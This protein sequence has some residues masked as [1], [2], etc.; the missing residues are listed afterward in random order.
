MKSKFVPLIVIMLISALT[1]Y[2]QNGKI[3]G[4]VL[5]GSNGSVLPDAVLKIEK[6]NKGTASD[7][8]GK[9]EF[10]GIVSGELDIKASYVGYVSQNVKV[11]LKSDDVLNV[12]FVLQPEGTS[13]DT[14]TIEAERIQSN[15][16]ALLLKQQ[17]A[18][19]IQDGI[20]SQQI[21][22]TGDATSSE[23]LKR[24]VGV[25]IVDNKFVFVRGTNERYSAT[26]LNGVVLPSTDPDKKAFSFDLF[27]S[28]L[29]DN[30]VISKSYTPDL[31]GNFSGGLVQVT[32]KDFPEQ[33]SLNLSMTS[34]Y[35]SITTGDNFLSY[36]AGESKILFFNSGR[37]NG[38]RKLP[39]IFPG[40]TVLSSNYNVQEVKSFSQ[41]FANNWQQEGSKAPLNGGFQFSLGNNFRIG[42]SNNLGFFGAYTYSN[43]FSSKSIERQNFQSDALLE[44]KYSGTQSEY[45]VMWGGL[46]NLSFRAGD[47]NKF[48]FKNTYVFN[49]EDETDY[50]EGF[51]NT[52]TQERKLYSTK[53]VQRDMLSSQFS[54][55]HFI[56]ELG[57]L[58]ITWRGAYSEAKRDEP[59][60]KT[61]RYQREINTN[62][63]FYASL[64]TGEPNSLGGGRFFSKLNDINRSLEANFEFSFKPVKKIEIKSK[65][66]VFYNKG[67]RDFN[68]RLFAPKLV[69]ANNFQIFYESPDSLFR[70]ENIDT[71]KILYYELTRQSDAYTASDDIAAGY[72][73]F[74][75]PIGK[76]RT[77]IGARL[78]SNLSKLS[79]FDQIGDPIQRNVNKNDLLPSLN[80]TYALSPSI[81]I[82][83]GYYQSISRPEF[84]EIAPFSFYDFAEQIFTIGNP[85]IERNLIRN[86]DLR[87]EYYPQAG[88]ILSLSLFYK[89]FDSPIEEVFVPNSGGDNRIKTFQNAKGGA[90]N[91]G[92]E[93]EARKNLGF[94]G[95]P[96]KYFSL[97]TNISIINSKVNLSG[98]GTTATNLERRL[99][100]Q[101]PYTINM[102]LYYDNSDL[103][104]S[105]NLSYNRFGKRISEVGLEGL[106]DIEENG[107]DVVDFSVIQRLYKN[108]EVKLMVKDILAQDYLYTQLVEGKEEMFKK[109]NAGMGLSLSLTFKY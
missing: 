94:I 42:K 1:V 21:K 16:A 30:I 33:L 4:K 52:Q 44:S 20:S 46:L 100:G 24:I 36:N 54:G 14:V 69:D 105:V 10:A 2:S 106:S 108:F 87:F 84:R 55:E 50:S 74:D 17:K 76:L 102:G 68:A 83:G 5:D 57:K 59:D 104:T 93:L 26:T 70:Q 43:S 92:I 79:S 25:S 27:P 72:L 66:G 8:D 41:A 45:A 99:Q 101:S 88:E 65:F 9:Y 18:D 63:R 23:V 75:I 67:T 29:L 40:N 97:N 11:S 80:L 15:D 35:N 47:N 85:E 31:V 53:F 7:L 77:V 73:M 90:N 3:T 98:I 32:T 107:R 64:S 109:I 60:Y 91:Y 62:D 82:R 13:T 48:S 56:R 39:A 19:N 96:F 6:L 12:D 78:E 71:N 38:S 51:N 89:K 37:D 58:R 49:S 22:R 61:L 34:S 28:N 86:Y 81:N 95:K 103:G